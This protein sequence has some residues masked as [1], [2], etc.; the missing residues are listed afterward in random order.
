MEPN[1]IIEFARI[2]GFEVDFQRD[3]RKGDEFEVM[4]DWNEEKQLYQVHVNYNA[5][6]IAQKLDFEDGE[7][8]E[9]AWAAQWSESLPVEYD[10]RTG[11]YSWN[12]SNSSDEKNLID[13]NDVEDVSSILTSIS[14]SRFSIS[15]SGGP[16]DGS[17]SV[18]L[19]LIH[20]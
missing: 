8:D 2:F 13:V 10:D 1:V 6:D 15:V 14:D 9:Q 19:S 12:Y 18:G 5:N 20:I 17:S 7:F 3:I 11:T 16:L 4:Y